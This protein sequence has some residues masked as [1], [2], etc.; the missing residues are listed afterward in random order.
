MSACNTFFYYP[1]RLQYTD[2]EQ[3]HFA[4]EDVRFKSLDGTLLSGWFIPAHIP[5]KS[6]GTII[7]FHGNAE[8]MSSHWL[9]LAWLPQNNYNLFTFDYR[10]YGPSQGTAEL[11]GTVKDSIAAIQYVRQRKDIDP[12]QLFL[13]GQSLGGALALAAAA[14]DSRAGIRAIIIE[15]AFSSY[16]LI[17]QEK[18]NESWVLWHFQWPIAWFLIQDTYNPERMLEKLGET[19]LL[20]VHGTDDRIVPYHHSRILYEKAKE[21]KY[22]WLV[23]GKG[24]LQVFHLPAYQKK[25]LDFLTKYSLPKKKPLS[26]RS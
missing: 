17:A 6:L 19:P 2:P 26:L 7:Q 21:P 5:E 10:G 11:E 9:S 24:H 18:L 14:G 3:F 16:S 13:V 23:E 20:F 15:S 1:S 22:F 4:H 12:R 8:N 25:L